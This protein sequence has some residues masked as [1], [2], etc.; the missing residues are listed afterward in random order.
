[1][2]ERDM[3]SNTAS[4]DAKVD[5]KEATVSKNKPRRGRGSADKKFAA[6]RTKMNNKV[7]E[8]EMARIRAFANFDG[9]LEVS[10]NIMS[11]INMTEATDSY[12]PIELFDINVDEAENV[13]TETLVQVRALNIQ[14]SAEEEAATRV[15]TRHQIAAKVYAGKL[16]TRQIAPIPAEYMAVRTQAPSNLSPI[17]TY[18]NAI[19]PVTFEKKV[20]APG[21]EHRI[22]VET[23]STFPIEFGAPLIRRYVRIPDDMMERLTIEGADGRR[24]LR[25]NIIANP[26]EL[27]IAGCQA[28]EDQP[29]ASFAG[30]L[31]LYQAMLSR[32]NKKK[33]DAI[34]DIG[35]DGEGHLCQLVNQTPL[36]ANRVTVWSPIPIPVPVLRL[37][38]IFGLGT[39]AAG[40]NPFLHFF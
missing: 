38:A 29:V 26:L 14:V 22:E 21:N 35:Y 6:N 34:R 23:G 36:D 40:E 25:P 9:L 37:G 15:V 4:K 13:I 31:R 7:Q 19:G 33:S 18:I 27:F 39:S 3:E 10:E 28:V 24:V 16:K 1:M 5:N 20:F 17:A 8:A 12:Y 30:N 2:S 11:D 32:V